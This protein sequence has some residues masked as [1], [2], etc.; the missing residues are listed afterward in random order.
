MSSRRDQGH[1]SRRKGNRRKSPKMARSQ[2]PPT[3]YRTSNQHP[4]ERQILG[5]CR[6]L[7]NQQIYNQ[8]NTKNMMSTGKINICKE[9]NHKSQIA[10]WLIEMMMWSVVMIG[11]KNTNNGRE[12]KNVE[13]YTINNRNRQKR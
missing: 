8:H 9:E 7:G 11:V 3:L 6:G 2:N 10:N 12:V 1:K 4:T 13:L 5:A